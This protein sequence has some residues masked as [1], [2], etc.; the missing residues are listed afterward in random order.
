[1]VLSNVW[2]TISHC[3]RPGDN[4]II[5]FPAL[6]IDDQNVHSLVNVGFIF[7]MGIYRVLVCGEEPGGG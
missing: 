5:L 1:M 3:K 7:G 4:G 2:L 6:N